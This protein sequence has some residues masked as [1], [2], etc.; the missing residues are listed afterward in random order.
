[1]FCFLATDF[2]ELNRGIRREVG[3]LSERWAI[4]LARAE[5]WQRQLDEMLPVSSRLK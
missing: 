4:L 5:D 2:Q 1:M 3:R